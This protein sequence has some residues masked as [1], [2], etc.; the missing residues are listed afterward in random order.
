M[1]PPAGAP[2]RRMAELALLLALLGLAVSNVLLREHLTVFEGDV[3][4]GL[5]CGQAGHFDCN[6]VAAHRSA[7]LIGLPLPFWGILFYLTMAVLA[8]DVRVLPLGQGAAAA[9]A[10]A[11]L[12]LAAVVFD[13]YLG[14]VMLTQI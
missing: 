3:A 5:F 13:A 9:A 8:L 12:A 2:G 1:T 11:I 7:W 10:G 6:T 4:G 14:V